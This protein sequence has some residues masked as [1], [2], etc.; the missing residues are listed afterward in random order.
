MGN[1]KKKKRSFET[2]VCKLT[3]IYHFLAATALKWI[4]MMEREV[5]AKMAASADGQ[6][7]YGQSVKGLLTE[8]VSTCGAD[9]I[10]LTKQVLKGSRSSEVRNKMS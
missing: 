9:V 3:Y 8:K 5:V 2:I 4:L 10:A 7:K 6:T 1:L